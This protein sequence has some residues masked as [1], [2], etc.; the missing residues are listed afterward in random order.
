MIPTSMHIPDCLQGA[1]EVAYGDSATVWQ[2]M[3]KGVRVAVKVFRIYLASNMDYHFSVSV[4]V[5]PL[6]LG[7]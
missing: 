7:V 1:V 3:H 6:H 2:S 5:A 4:L